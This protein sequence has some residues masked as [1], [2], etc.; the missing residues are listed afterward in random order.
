MISPH[1]WLTVLQVNG[2][3]CLTGRQRGDNC[4]RLPFRPRLQ[5]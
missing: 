5:R 4:L 3:E 1:L 2:V